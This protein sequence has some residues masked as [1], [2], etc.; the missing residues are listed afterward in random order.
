MGQLG[1]LNMFSGISHNTLSIRKKSYNKCI[2]RCV[3]SK[4]YHK[5]NFCIN[6]NGNNTWKT[7]Y[8]VSEKKLIQIRCWLW[9]KWDI[10][11]IIIIIV[12]TSH[13][14]VYEY[15]TIVI[16]NPS[17]NKPFFNRSSIYNISLDKRQTLVMVFNVYPSTE[18]IY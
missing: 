1:T 11:T 5:V 10:N 16:R 18:R 6:K 7:S 17:N 2:L 9:I 3:Y 4:I 8:L 14:L 12:K 15:F 13:F